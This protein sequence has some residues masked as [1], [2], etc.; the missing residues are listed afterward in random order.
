MHRSLGSR[1]RHLID[2]NL[3]LTLRTRNRGLGG[4]KGWPVRQSRTAFPGFSGIADVRSLGTDVVNKSTGTDCNGEEVADATETLVEFPDTF[5]PKSLSSGQVVKDFS[6][7][8]RVREIHEAV[9][10]KAKGEA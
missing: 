4:T 3:I 9:R 10:G 5:A 2:P 8:L 7:R 6:S 1:R